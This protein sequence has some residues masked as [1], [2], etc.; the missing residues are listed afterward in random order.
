MS[1]PFPASFSAF[2]SLTHLPLMC[3]Q[4]SAILFTYYFTMDTQSSLHLYP[5]LHFMLCGTI[6]L[7][8]C[9]LLKDW[10]SVAE[11]WGE[12]RSLRTWFETLTNSLFIPYLCLINQ[13]KHK[14]G[15]YNKSGPQ[16]EIGTTINHTHPHSGYCPLQKG[17]C[18][19]QL[20]SHILSQVLQREVPLKQSHRQKLGLN[21]TPK[22]TLDHPQWHIPTLQQLPPARRHAV[23]P[24]SGTMSFYL[25][26]PQEA[27]IKKMRR[28]NWNDC[29]PSVP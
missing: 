27:S 13:L 26:N 18:Y 23:V 14:W 6:R 8:M 1:S 20:Q 10:N 28:R 11:W 16:N 24:G 12:P 25:G 9:N 17:A 15:K 21:C 22:L 4:S 5:E 19:L 2:C 3:P 29:M 7:R